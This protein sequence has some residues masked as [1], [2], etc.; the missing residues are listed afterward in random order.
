MTRSPARR[1]AVFLPALVLGLTGALRAI[2]HVRAVDAVSLFAGG[3][4]FGVGVVGVV[5]LVRG[6]RSTQP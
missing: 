5:K 1:W 4:A 3:M 2:P 6:A